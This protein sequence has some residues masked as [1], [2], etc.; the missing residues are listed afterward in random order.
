[1]RRQ[2]CKSRRPSRNVGV[3]AA[4]RAGRGLNQVPH[5]LS[6]GSQVIGRAVHCRRHERYA[7]DH[8]DP[9]VSIAATLSGLFDSSRTSRMPKKRMM[10]AGS[11]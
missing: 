5:F 11:A 3:G 4:A 9:G 2:R 10:A 6:L 8:P 7:L 1:M